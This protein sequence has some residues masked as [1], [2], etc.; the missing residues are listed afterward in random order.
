MKRGSCVLMVLHIMNISILIVFLSFLYLNFFDINISYIKNSQEEIIVQTKYNI[1]KN[2]FVIE[3]Y[4][5]NIIQQK[6][7]IK[8][9]SDIEVRNYT[10]KGKSLSN[11]QTY[12]INQIK[13]EISSV[14]NCPWNY[15]SYL[16]IDDMTFSNT[17]NN[18]SLKK[19]TQYTIY[20]FWENVNPNDYEVVYKNSLSDDYY[21]FEIIN[22]IEV[23]KGKY[24]FKTPEDTCDLQIIYLYGFENSNN[25][26]EWVTSCFN[27]RVK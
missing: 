9:H 6:I 18:L 25:E 27:F 1:I 24:V 16:Y 4:K 13:P 3:K 15:K 20:T 5:Y 8:S 12:C 19:N 21:S 22:N 11:V 26:D 7:Y 10:N 23:H 2:I 14:L 17:D